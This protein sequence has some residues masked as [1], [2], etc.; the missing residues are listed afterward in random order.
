MIEVAIPGYK[1]LKLKYLVLDFN[2]TLSC[3]GKLLEGV[4]ERLEALSEDL[5]IHVLTADTFGRAQ[6]QLEGIPCELFVLPLKGQDRGKLEYIERFGSK[7]TVCVGNGRNDRLMI[8]GAALGI[9]VV[10][11]EGAAVETLMA[12]DVVCSSIFS[13]LDLLSNPLRLVATLRS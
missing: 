7:L 3:D 13:A 2:G 10:L 6:A 9:A 1:E 4:K 5:E 8:E 11:D 12:A